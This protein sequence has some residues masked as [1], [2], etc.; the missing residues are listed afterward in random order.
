MGRRRTSAGPRL[1]TR[2]RPQPTLLVDAGSQ[3]RASV[4]YP[5]R[6]YELAW[7]SP[8][9]H[10]YAVF[11]NGYPLPPRPARHVSGLR[12]GVHTSHP[13]VACSVRVS[14]RGPPLGNPCREGSGSSKCQVAVRWTNHHY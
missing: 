4:G 14:V 9:Y 10:L 5:R 8:R 12:E 13:F 11:P 7:P 3:E 2:H 6:R 1:K